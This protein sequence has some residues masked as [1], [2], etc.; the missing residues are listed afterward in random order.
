M[1]TALLILAIAAAPVE[2]VEHKL[3]TISQTEQT[4]G[5]PGIRILV[6]DNYREIYCLEACRWNGIMCEFMASSVRL[7][8][9]T[10][11][12]TYCC[13]FKQ[14]PTAAVLLKVKSLIMRG[15]YIMFSNAK[16]LFLWYLLEFYIKIMILF[17][18][19][20]MIYKTCKY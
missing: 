14:N 20:L 1:Q 18:V 4:G 5:T 16:S 9:C 6:L 3:V 8:A 19:E 7:L 15:E 11:F 12:R 17:A 13:M 2:V 10:R